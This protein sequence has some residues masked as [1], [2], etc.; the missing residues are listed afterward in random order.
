MKAKELRL[1][2]YSI[3]H[4]WVDFSCALLMFSQLSGR[5]E[6][7]LCVLFY[8]FCAFALQMPIGLVADRL[9]RNG[10]AAALGCGGRR[11]LSHRG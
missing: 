9:N 5:R 10:G 3:G 8:N 7:A 4:F 11:A 1:C 2:V 6:W